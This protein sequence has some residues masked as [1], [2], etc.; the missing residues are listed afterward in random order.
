MGV[1]VLLTD[2]SLCALGRCLSATLSVVRCTPRVLVTTQDVSVMDVVAGHFSVIEVGSGFTQ[3]E[4]LQLFA[5]Y[6]N[7]PVD[8]LPEEAAAIHQECKVITIGY[9]IR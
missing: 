8:A 7:V 4:T 2:K 5:S 9:I 6:V 1:T 3:E